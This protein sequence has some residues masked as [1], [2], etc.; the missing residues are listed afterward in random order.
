MD[1]MASD[2]ESFPLSPPPQK[3]IIFLASEAIFSLSYSFKP[4]EMKF[5]GE[6]GCLKADF[7]SGAKYLAHDSCIVEI[8]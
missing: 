7:H 3:K 6:V 2:F 1:T 5:G 4:D 8:Q